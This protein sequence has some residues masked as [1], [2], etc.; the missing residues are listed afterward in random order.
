MSGMSVSGLG[1]RRG[2]AWLFRQLNFGVDVGRMLWIRGANGAGKT[3][4]LRI[5]AGLGRADEGHV[6]FS[7][8]SSLLYVGHANALKDDLT[9]TESLEFL[10]QLHGLAVDEPTLA[11]ALKTLGI[12]H[13]RQA[14]VRTLSQGQRRRVALARLALAPPSGVWILDE[15]FDALDS[16]GIQA[17]S[18]LMFRHASRGGSLAY[19]SHLEVDFPQGSCDQLHL[20]DN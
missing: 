13:R 8:G 1:A 4:L 9:V 2:N 11:Q 7:A 14:Y 17:V 20:G 3:T 10:V 16:Q 12:F 15:P 5:L 19:T 18:D 6:E